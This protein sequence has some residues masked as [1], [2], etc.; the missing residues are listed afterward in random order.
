[1]SATPRSAA[2]AILAA[3]LL[4]CGAGNQP[5]A[6]GLVGPFSQDRGRSMQLGAELAVAEINAAGGVHGRPLKLVI[7]DDSA[8]PEVAVPAARTLY[9]DPSVVA[10][11]GHLTSATTLAAAPIYG[12][13]RHPLAAISPSASAPS[14][15]QAGPYIFRVCPTDVAHGTQLA[16]F[17]FHRLG[18]R[19]AGILYQNDEYG[20]GIRVT[21]SREFTRLG[22]RLVSDDPYVPELPSF[23]PYLRRLR[24]R[25]G[26]DVLLIAGTAAAA[27]RVL[28]TLDTVGLRLRV[29][30]GD[31]LSGLETQRRAEGVLMSAAYLPDRPGERN[32]AF[33]AAYRAAYPGQPLDHRGAAA[34]D[35]VYLLARGLDA[36][37][38]DRRRL[39]DYLAGVGQASPPYQGV[40]GTIAF[41]DLGDVPGKEVVLGVVRDGHL[42]MA[43]H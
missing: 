16:Q 2:A 11:I 25:G 43:Q 7:E 1:V 40:T 17:A 30:G 23:E 18:A 39:R 6:L 8:K 13:G 36:V 5:I 34:Y 22:G 38:A 29:L 32:A 15:S 10:V 12:G 19:Q 42:V 26:A 9:A 27:Q 41:D 37:G 4:G 24:Q 14:V 3:A 31:A 21:F 28:P 35:V 20:R 33:A